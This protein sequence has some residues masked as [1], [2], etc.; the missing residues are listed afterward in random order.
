MEKSKR[1]LIEARLQDLCTLN[2]GRLTPQNVVADA[3][4][5]N[6]PL[7]DIFEWDDAKAAD[8]YR[9]EQARE[10]IRSVK[11]E[12]VTEERT[13]STIRYIRDPTL[14][15]KEPGYVETMRIRTDKDVAIEALRAEISRLSATMERVESLAI[16]LDLT[17]E[18]ENFKTGYQLLALRVQEA[19]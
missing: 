2:K 18:L 4:N 1:A 12:V 16:V 19:A 6:S 5:R 3:R 15:A 9:L 8:Q 14:A 10:L 11:I 17:A 7:H 13:V